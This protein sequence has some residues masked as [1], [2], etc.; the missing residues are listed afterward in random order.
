MMPASSK[1][2]SRRL[3]LAMALFCVVVWGVSYAVIRETVQQIPPLSLASLRHL[4]GAALLW[5]LTRARFGAV[6]IP[7]RHHAVMCGLALCG[8]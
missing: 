4:V 3:A 7:P 8:I 5:P 2:I 6:P 1:P